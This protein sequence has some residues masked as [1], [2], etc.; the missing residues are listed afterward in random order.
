MQSIVKKYE[1][2]IIINLANEW[3]HT[4]WG[5]GNDINETIFKSKYNTLVV[6]LRNAGIKCPIMIDAPNFGTSS[7]ALIS[8]G[9]NIVNNDPLKNILLS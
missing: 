9:N 2:K 8:Y 1:N 6:Q 3:G 4:G 7:E 5:D